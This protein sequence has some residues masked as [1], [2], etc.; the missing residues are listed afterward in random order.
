MNIYRCKAVIKLLKNAKKFLLLILCVLSSSSLVESSPPT[1]LRLL[2]S[3]CFFG[4]SA[5]EEQFTR[6]PT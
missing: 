1:F 5:T 3:K 6:D 2:Q 4:E